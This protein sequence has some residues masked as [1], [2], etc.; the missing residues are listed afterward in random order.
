[1]NV[2]QK[3][4]RRT[5]LLIT[6]IFFA[7][8]L[9]AAYMYFSG[10]TWRPAESTQYGELVSPPRTMPDINLVTDAGDKQLFG[11]WNLLVLADAQCDPGCIQAL[12]NIRQIR[13]SLGPKM[14]RLQTVFLP[15]ANSAVAA[16]L[17]D[18]HPALIIVNPATS[19][20]LRNIVGN[21]S[22]GQ[23]FIVDPLGNLMMQY[24]PGTLMGDIRKDLGHLLQLSGIG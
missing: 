2:A 6:A 13:L 9:L 17:A 1:M 18:N 24:A 16:D 10:S 4:G 20:D 7:P 5:L 15:A 8:I 23:I 19:Q 3:R 14:T 11:V 21:Y 22:N 12:E